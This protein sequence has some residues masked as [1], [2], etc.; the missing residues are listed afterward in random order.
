METTNIYEKKNIGL[1]ISTICSIDNAELLQQI[2]TTFEKNN[3]TLDIIVVPSQTKDITPFTTWETPTGVLSKDLLAKVDV[4]FAANDVTTGKWADALALFGAIK[5]SNLKWLQISWIGIDFPIVQELLTKQ[6]FMITN[7]KGANAMP[8]ATSALAGMLSLNRALNYWMI[9]KSKKEWATYN[10][11]KLIRDLPLERRDINNQIVLIYGFGAIG[12]TLG[13]LCKS[14]NMQVIGVKRTMIDFDNTF[15]DKIIQPKDVDM[16]ISEADFVAIT[17]P[18][19]PETNGFFGKERLSKMK[20]SSFLVN[21]GRGAVCDESALCELLK[22]KAI[23]GAYLDAFI[24][25]PLPSE[26]ELWDLENVIISPHDSATCKDNDNR[27]I[28]IFEENMNNLA[29]SKT[30]DNI[31]FKSNNTSL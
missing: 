18:L 17:S 27:V 20:S 9:S 3:K 11:G 15:A 23:A 19:T 22:T 13:R 4:A 6:N 10:G 31:V 21:V 14:L 7:A 5:E 8:I 26:N 30:L 25:E 24:E 2:K 1:L 28:K 16:Y 29:N 12:Q